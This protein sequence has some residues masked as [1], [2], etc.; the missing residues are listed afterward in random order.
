[1]PRHKVL[2]PSYLE[3]KQGA[4][5]GEEGGEEQKSESVFIKQTRGGGGLK[6]CN[7][8]LFPKRSIEPSTVQ[9]L[10]KNLKKH[11]VTHTRTLSFLPINH[12]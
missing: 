7:T 9:K 6:K 2:L 10:E 8:L 11:T 5:Q 1:M 12:G 3:Q 4:P